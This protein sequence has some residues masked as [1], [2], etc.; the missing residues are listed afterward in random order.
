MFLLFLQTTAENQLKYFHYIHLSPYRFNMKRTFYLII[1]V[2][3]AYVVEQ[4]T[5]IAIFDTSKNQNQSSKTQTQSSSNKGTLSLP[6]TQSTPKV[7]SSGYS[8]QSAYYNHKSDV[9]IQ[10]K[11]TVVKLLSDDLSG[12]RHQRF[13]LK[14]NKL[15]VLIAHNID[16]APRIDALRTGDTVEFYGEYE[17]NEKGG[18]VHW[19]HH[20]PAGRHA[21]GW[22]KHKGKTYQ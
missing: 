17:W 13:I 7:Q 5:G 12:S 4:K 8:V 2:V 10:E 15:S 1:L 19:T 16:L 11:G 14:F 21:S 6:T 22:L 3:V 20:D 18:I 9:Q